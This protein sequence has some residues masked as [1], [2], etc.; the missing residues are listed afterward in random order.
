MSEPHDPGN[1]TFP[2]AKLQQ[3][4]TL[5]AGFYVPVESVELSAVWKWSSFH[6][7]GKI[8]KEITFE[9]CW[10]NVTFPHNNFLAF[11]TK[12]LCYLQLPANA[13]ELTG[14]DINI[15]PSSE[16]AVSQVRQKQW[17]FGTPHPSV[18]SNFLSQV[19]LRTKNWN[20]LQCLDITNVWKTGGNLQ[21]GWHFLLLANVL[22]PCLW[23]VNSHHWGKTSRF[24]RVVKNDVSKGFTYTSCLRSLGFV[25]SLCYRVSGSVGNIFQQ[26]GTKGGRF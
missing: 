6:F 26:H 13:R 22:L 23:P 10:W 25:D 2:G 1:V 11:M 17:V 12:I 7:K 14:R 4:R 3:L 9:K 16:G 15:S 20:T 18:E 8:W 21:R 5:W 24:S 19:S